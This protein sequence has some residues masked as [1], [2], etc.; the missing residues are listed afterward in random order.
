VDG[1]QADEQFAGDLAVAQARGHQPQDLDLA[2]R[3]TI[4]V[5]GT[6]AVCGLLRQKFLRRD[7]AP[8]VPRGSEGG[9]INPLVGRLK[10]AF[11]GEFQPGMPSGTD[12]VI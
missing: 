12:L 2:G 8:S 7:D 11:I 10:G 9:F 6:R 1:A 3:Q 4:C 5:G